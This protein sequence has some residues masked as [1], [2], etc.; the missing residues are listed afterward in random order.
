MVTLK[1]DQRYLTCWILDMFE[2]MKGYR[3]LL[4]EKHDIMAYLYAVPLVFGRA[5]RCSSLFHSISCV[6]FTCHA[7]PNPSVSPC[8]VA[9]IFVVICLYEFAVQI[10]RTTSPSIPQPCFLRRD[11]LYSARSSM[12]NASKNKMK[13]NLYRNIQEI[14]HKKFS[15]NCSPVQTLKKY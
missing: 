4:V 9:N 6:C 14:W 7:A 1:I 2:R 15:I 5:E 3:K 8:H 11:L 13:P 12:R 10:W